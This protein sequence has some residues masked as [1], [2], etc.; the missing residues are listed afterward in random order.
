MRGPAWPFF[1]LL[2]ARQDKWSILVD[3]MSNVVVLHLDFDEVYSKDSELK[4][5]LNIS[6]YVSLFVDIHDVNC[7]LFC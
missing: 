1:W 7:F 5:R 6:C 2:I 4:Q 3:N